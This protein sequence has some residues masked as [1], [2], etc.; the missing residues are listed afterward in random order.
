[1]MMPDSAD[2]RTRLWRDDPEHPEPEIPLLG[3]DVTVGDIIKRRESWLERNAAA[4]DA[5]L[6][7]A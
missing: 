5:A 4:L 6:M 3:G 7:A 1:M 2:P